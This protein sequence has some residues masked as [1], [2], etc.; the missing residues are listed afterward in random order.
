MCH[1]ARRN[2]PSVAVC[3]PTS[4]CILTTSRIAS[5]SI[6]A[7]RLVVD[8]VVGV[9]VTGLQQLGRPQEAADMVGAVGG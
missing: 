3:S 5:S 7:Q 2:S 8:A 6:A 1:E 4:C 9:I